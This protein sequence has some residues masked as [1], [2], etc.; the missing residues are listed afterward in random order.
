[1]KTKY[2]KARSQGKS[3]VEKVRRRQ[4]RT[5]KRQNGRT[6]N[7]KASGVDQRAME[8]ALPVN[9]SE[10]MELLSESLHS[11]AV[12]M[13][14]LVAGKLLKD[15]V[16]RLC[17]ERYQHSVDREFTRYGSQ[18]GGITL[19]AQRVAI[20]KPRVRST[21]GRGET[22]LETYA[23]MQNSDAMPQAVLA[24]MVRG[25]SCR[26]YQG[27][28]DVARE[29]FGVKKSSVSRHFV[30]AS[31][32]ELQRLA[33]RRFDDVRLVAIYM[34][35]VQYAGETMVCALGLTETGHKM[36]LGLREGASENALVVTALLEELRDRGIDTKRKTL[37]VIDGSQAL[38]KALKDVWGQNAV[39][40]R[41]QVHKKRNVMA[42]LPAKHHDECKKRINAAY[43]EQDYD[44]AL[45][46]LRTTAT[47]LKGINPDAAASLREGLEE[48]LTV[49][50]L[51][52]PKLLRQT[53]T[54][55]NP[56]ESAFDVCRRVTSRV[57]RWKEGDMRK[58]WCAS[59]LLKAERGF[60]RVKGYKAI[61]KLIEALDK[62]DTMTS[63]AA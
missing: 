3:R 33:D 52:L 48:T 53:L 1:M 7:K 32:E 51:G 40:Q 38:R 39:V 30:R 2:R 6:A 16:D 10:L 5:D 26:D 44:K 27:A 59:G 19:A 23:L 31:A 49:I 41:C 56:I 28:V 34:D 9:R 36:I 58:R 47:W 14:L 17:G 22:S 29:G 24:R 43:H 62:F 15:E 21:D 61:P 42:H 35:G 46:T 25:V 37:F 4:S 50:R 60:R 57:K 20:Q 11:F 12:E 18:P 8:F 13:G 45:K 63:R 54:T 55:T